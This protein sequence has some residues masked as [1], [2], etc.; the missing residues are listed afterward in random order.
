M[1][2]SVENALATGVSSDA[3][4]CAAL[5]AASVF[6]RER[7][8]ESNAGRIADCPRGARQ[9]PHRQQHALHVRVGDDCTGAALLALARIGHCLLQ[10]ALGDADALQADREPRAVHHR[11]HAGH[12]FVLFADEVATAPPL[13]P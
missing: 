12:A 7:T 13:S 8:V 3:R 10:C 5:R 6:A 9:R 2:I 1:P 4:S 11:E